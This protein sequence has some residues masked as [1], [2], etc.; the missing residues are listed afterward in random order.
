MKEVQQQLL[1]MQKLFS[2]LGNNQTFAQ[3]YYNS[4]I[5][6]G[7]VESSKS[8]DSSNS[9]TPDS[10]QPSFGLSCTD[11]SCLCPSGTC[12][13]SGI[14]DPQIDHRTNSIDS[15]KSSTKS[16]DTK[17]NNPDCPQ[18]NCNDVSN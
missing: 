11:D 6:I 9:D 4:R 17:E 5:P 13:Y 7:H 1:E 2:N 16:I 3:F 14:N 15:S 18:G 12:H 10:R 8:V